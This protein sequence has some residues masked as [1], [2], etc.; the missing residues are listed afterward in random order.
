MYQIDGT[1]LKDR[2]DHMVSP[3]LMVNQK[4]VAYF[5][6]QPGYYTNANFHYTAHLQKN[7]AIE[8]AFQKGDEWIYPS[9]AGEI[10]QNRLFIEEI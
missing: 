9:A 3:I 10:S 1:L 4:I 2:G 8:I 6:T 7:D 5:Y